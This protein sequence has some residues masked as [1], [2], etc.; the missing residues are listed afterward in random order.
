MED[1]HNT[2]KYQ[3]KRQF[4]WNNY[5]SRVLQKISPDIYIRSS[6]KE[7]IGDILDQIIH[8][9]I[10][11]AVRIAEHSGK[12]TIN[13]R[14]IQSAVRIYIKSELAKHAIL[15]GNKA[16]TKYT[17]SDPGDKKNP[18]H[19]SKRADIIFPVTRMDK[20]LKETAM[21]NENRL[22]STTSIYLAAVMEYLT[23]E[24]LELAATQARNH[25]HTRITPRDVGLAISQDEELNN[26]I[27]KKGLIQSGT[28]EILGFGVV[29]YIHYALNQSPRRYGYSYYEKNPNYHSYYDLILEAIVQNGIDNLLSLMKIKS[30]VQNNRPTAY[31]NGMFLRVLN[32][33][34]DKKKLIKKKGSFGLSTKTKQLLEKRRIRK[35][36]AVAQE[37]GNDLHLEDSI[38]KISDNS[39]K[40]IMSRGGVKSVGSDSYST[41]RSIM[42]NYLHQLVYS[43]IQMAIHRGAKTISYLDYKNSAKEVGLEA[44]SSETYPF[45]CNKRLRRNKK[46]LDGEEGGDKDIDEENQQQ[47]GWNDENLQMNEDLELD[48]DDD[49]NQN[50]G[51]LEDHE[52][53]DD[54]DD[55]EYNDLETNLIGGANRKKYRHRSGYHSLQ[56]IRKHQKTGCL[57]IPHASIVRVI[58]EIADH[59]NPGIRHSK[60]S[61]SY[62]HAL[63]ENHMTSISQDAILCAL[64]DKRKIVKKHDIELA[65]H[66]RN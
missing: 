56:S 48:S 64:H 16:V 32:N 44:I 54:D 29:P 24:I 1:Q 45:N 41:M 14:E 34:V 4:R 26:L 57:F 66:L 61:M 2:R 20:L 21:H 10:I 7:I 43:A 36:N 23:A 51:W 47:G 58:R 60:T 8:E 25:R 65:L 37:G 30:H 19:K 59:Y 5:I 22:G 63:I 17:N 55:S 33:A 9:I 40:K 39:I 49:E 42:G 3:K 52:L 12:K 35:M 38:S 27:I 15:E 13:S 18:I 53:D 6:S 46:T 11:R 31:R 62:A 50:G 28:K